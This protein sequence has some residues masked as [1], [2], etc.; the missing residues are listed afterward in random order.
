MIRLV[1]GADR[2]A[3]R[4]RLRDLLDAAPDISVV[5]EAVNAIST[6][7]QARRYRPDVVLLLDDPTPALCVLEVAHT[8]SSSEPAIATVLCSEE[9]VDGERARQAGIVAVL[10]REARSRELIHAIRRAAFRHRRRPA[11]AAP[12]GGS[13]APLPRR[14]RPVAA[15]SFSRVFLLVLAEFDLLTYAGLLVCGV[16][17]AFIEMQATLLPLSWLVAA[18]TATAL[19]AVLRRRDSAKV[20]SGRIGSRRPVESMRLTGRSSRW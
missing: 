14:G 9:V 15:P 8:L 6:L 16:P 4:A 1:I 7:R 13:I 2:T 18:A 11:R 20:G 3:V 10:G 19:W 17:V 5:G 12:P